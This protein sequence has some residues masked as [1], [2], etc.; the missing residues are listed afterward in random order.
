MRRRWQSRA[1]IC[2]DCTPTW[3]S[4]RENSLIW[5]RLIAGSR[6]ARKPCF[7]GIER[8]KDGDEPAHQ[9]ESNN[10]EREQDDAN[11]RHRDHHAQATKNSVMKKSR[12]AVTRA[13]T[14]S[15]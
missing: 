2:S 4:T 10:D 12:K 3:I 6:L 5:P 11:A 14:S 8:R 13:V 9:R 7:I 15:A 1:S